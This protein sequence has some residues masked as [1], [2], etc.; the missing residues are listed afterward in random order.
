M[1]IPETMLAEQCFTDCFGGFSK[2][3][4]KGR[5]CQFIE[6]RGEMPKG[7][8]A[9]DGGESN[10]GPVSGIVFLLNEYRK[11]DNGSGMKHMPQFSKKLCGALN[12]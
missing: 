1:N 9:K 3:N 10:G 8:G 5:C 7:I 6:L 2:R 12:A 4:K 11:F